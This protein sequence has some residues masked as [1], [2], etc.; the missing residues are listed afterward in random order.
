MS[1]AR[2]VSPASY[3]II[4]DMRRNQAIA[5]VGLLLIASFFGFILYRM[6]AGDAQAG[7]IR[8]Q[9]RYVT[10][11]ASFTNWQNEPPKPN[12]K[13]PQDAVLSFLLW[14]SWGYYSGDID[15]ASAV[16]TPFQEPRTTAYFMKLMQEDLRINQRLDLLEVV[17]IEKEEFKSSKPGYEAFSERAQVVTREEWTFNY[18]TL[19]TQEWGAPQRAFYEVSYTV[20]RDSAQ[21]WF[22]DEIEIVSQ[23]GN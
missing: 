18:Q 5:T 17:S 3:P 8:F 16:M 21:G 15:S 12:H 2:F 22:V 7:I 14:V 11:E 19:S 23:E 13:T 10:S 9:K 4:K 20:L 1:V 6:V